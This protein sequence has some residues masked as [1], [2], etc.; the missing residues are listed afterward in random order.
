VRDTAVA[1]VSFQGGEYL[2]RANGWS[3]RATLA[4]ARAARRAPGLQPIYV[5]AVVASLLGW[6]GWQ[7]GP[8]LYH[9]LSGQQRPGNAGRIA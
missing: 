8:R 1:R 6:R 3:P 2:L 4:F 5:G 9:A 7:L